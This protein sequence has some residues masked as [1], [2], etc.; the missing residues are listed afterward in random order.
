MCG[1]SGGSGSGGSLSD[2]EIEAINAYTRGSDKINRALFGG[3]EASAETRE[4]IEI[5][6]RILDKSTITKKEELYRGVQEKHFDKTVSDLKPGDVFTY[7]GFMS[8]TKDQKLARTFSDW[9]GSQDLLVKVTVK[10][11][12]KALRIRSKSGDY[13][14]KREI[15]KEI[16]VGRGQKFIYK[17]MTQTPDAR[18]LNIEYTR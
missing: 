12:A 1:G 2:P 6:D 7:R 11:G 10:P 16:L 8:T 17:G 13:M 4:Q 14:D 3:Q 15:G 9:K 5:L 18:I